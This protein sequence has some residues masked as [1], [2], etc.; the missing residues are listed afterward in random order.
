MP[1]DIGESIPNDL[2]E[3]G[4]G[5]LRRRHSNSD[6]KEFIRFCVRMDLSCVF[7]SHGLQTCFGLTIPG[8]IMVRSH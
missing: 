5:S 2:I 4:S 3:L 8:F 1:T 7:E 6:S